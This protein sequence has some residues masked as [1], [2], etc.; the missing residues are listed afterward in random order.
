M[1]LTIQSADIACTPSEP[2]KPEQTS[3][4]V[5]AVIFGQPS[6]SSRYAPV[7]KCLSQVNPPILVAL[8]T[9][10]LIDTVFLWMPLIID[11]NAQVFA[12]DRVS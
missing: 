5:D 11:S 2:D 12:S 6:P 8:I 4:E 1:H 3:L 10:S 7:T 9:V